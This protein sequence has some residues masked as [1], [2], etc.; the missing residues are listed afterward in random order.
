MQKSDPYDFEECW[1]MVFNKYRNDYEKLDKLLSYMPYH[2]NPYV[3]FK[4]FTSKE[5]KTPHLWQ[6]LLQIVDEIRQKKKIFN[7]SKKIFSAEKWKIVAKATNKVNNGYVLSN[8]RLC[9]I[10]EQPV[11]RYRK[12]I[13]FRDNGP[14][15][16]CFPSCK[17]CYHPECL[18]NALG[19][20]EV[21]FCKTCFEAQMDKSVSNSSNVDGGRL[22]ID[23]HVNSQMR[24]V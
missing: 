11:I 15:I 10:C 5:L 18:Q 21:I 19:S 17:H 1:D 2:P 23:R 20:S 3:C 8:E 22:T 4:K 12:E 9:E 13:R 6:R 24:L 7:S 14:V 16:I